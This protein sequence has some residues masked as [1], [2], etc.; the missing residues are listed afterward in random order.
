MSTRL[1]A[2]RTASLALVL[3]AATVFACSSDRPGAGTG[4]SSG[5]PF[6]GSSGGPGDDQ[7]APPS[8]GGGDSGFPFGTIPTVDEPDIPCVTTTAPKTTLFTAADSGGL[9]GPPIQL[10]QSLGGGRF[11]SGPNFEGFITFDATGA[12]PKQIA[13]PFPGSLVAWV[14]LGT[15]VGAFVG[16][17]GLKFQKF[18]TNGV[19]Q[20][21]P[22]TIAAAGDPVIGVYAASDKSGGAMVVWVAN[23]TIH[24]AYINAAGALAGTPW[25]VA[26]NASTVRVSMAARDDG[27]YMIVYSY[28]VATDTIQGTVQLA[29]ANG[30]V[31]TPRDLTKLFGQL[32]PAG[33]VATSA[34]WLLSFDA[35]GDDR[36]FLVPLNGN[37]DVVPPARR[38]LGGDQPW[39]LASAGTSVGVVT[40]SNDTLVGGKEGPRKPQFRPVDSAG[41]PLGAWVCLDGPVP[42]KQYQDMGVVADGSG[43]SIVY[44]SVADETVLMRTNLL[45]TGPQ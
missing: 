22:V 6:D 10:V 45:G 42:S 1:L 30:A 40:M 39:A 21:A 28:T 13:S 8:D 36:V 25:T 26:S 34:G 38:L 32:F 20:G 43:W 18:D 35:G 33:V 11:G 16:D 19:A 7:T 24:A 14:S 3:A 9:G 5:Q 23:T 17:T 41:H 15:S 37:G 31:G 29:D 12:N 27:K 2:L 4:S 44:K